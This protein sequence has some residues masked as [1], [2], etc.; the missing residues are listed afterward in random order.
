MVGVTARGIS[1]DLFASIVKLC[2]KAPYKK[3]VELWASYIKNLSCY[4]LT[5]NLTSTTMRKGTCSNLGDIYN[6]IYVENLR[7]RHFPL[8]DQMSVNLSYSHAVAFSIG[9]Y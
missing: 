7:G 9:K 3:H 5:C 8:M 4:D 2:K 1:S 6:T